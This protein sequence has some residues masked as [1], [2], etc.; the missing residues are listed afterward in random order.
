M[1]LR[2]FSFIVKSDGNKSWLCLQGQQRGI[3]F[4]KYSLMM[5][6]EDEMNAA[7]TINHTGGKT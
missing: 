3:S 2:R 4:E 1:R 6:W 5:D 7:M